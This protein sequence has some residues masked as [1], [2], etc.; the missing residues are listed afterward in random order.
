MATFDSLAHCS[1]FGLALA[2]TAPAPASAQS[3][4]QASP[5]QLEPVTVTARV[6][7]VASVAGWGDVPLSRAPLQA[8]VIGAEQIKERGAHR[9]SEL[10]GLDP[11]LGDSYNTEGYWDYLSVR[12]FVLDNRFNYRRD[13]LPINAETSIPLDNKARIEVLKGLSGLQAGTSAPGGLVNYVVKRPTEQPLSLATLEWQ[14]RASVSAAVDLS[15]RFG[16]GEAFGARVNAE[17]ARL[18]PKQRNAAG[19]RHLFALAAEWRLGAS[20]LIEVEAETSRRSQ[21]SVPGFSMLGNA[22]PDA[23]NIDPRINL[24]NQTW[25]QPVVLKGNTASMRISQRLDADWSVVAHAMTQRLRSDDRAAFPFGVYDPNTFLCTLC[26]RFAA[27]GTYTLWQFVSDNERRRTDALDLSVSGRL[28]TGEVRHQVQAGALHS[29][30]R[31]R[32][33]QQVFDIAGTGDITGTA[34]TPPSS[35]FLDENTNRDERSNELQLRDAISLD[36]KL[37]VWLGLRHT[38]L[39]RDSVRTDGSRPTAYTQQ[40][41][42]PWLAASYSLTAQDLIYASWGKGIESEVVPNLPI[43]TNRGEALPALRSRQFEISWKRSDDNI[44]WAL[45]GFDIVRPAFTDLGSCDGNDSCTRAIDGTVGHRGAEANGALRQGAWTLRGGAQWLRAR[46][47]DSQVTAF[48]GKQPINVPALTLKAQ[49]GYAVPQFPGLNL[50]AGLIRESRRMLLSDNSASIPGYTRLDA[51]M[52]FAR[53]V[54]TV[55]WTWRVGVDNLADT[56]AWKDSPLQFGHV[57]LFPLA[58]RTWRTSL[59]AEL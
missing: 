42:T 49:L 20:T 19:E 7:G 44:D 40:V 28:R 47:M 6:P 13:G 26:D 5:T 14:E 59:Q 10:I 29:T 57:Y 51:G 32:L 11:A 9:L 30:Y 50:Q 39:Q 17:S 27:D 35:G 16:D 36:D 54:G 45:T 55:H 24:N 18:D 48:N 58:P 21:P 8:S 4:S 46:R 22:V 37:T 38:R 43:Y 56:R 2:C 25:S 52:Q 33:G 15:R 3:P 31:A 41:T 1:A 23:R 53:Q 12:G 34:V